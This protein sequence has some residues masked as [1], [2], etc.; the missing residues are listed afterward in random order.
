MKDYDIWIE[1]EHW[2]PGE[3]NPTNDNTDVIVT[4]SDKSRW[5]A[6]FFTYS[7][8][9]TLRQMHAASGEC[10]GG[11]YFWSS[12]MIL[13]DDTSRKSIETVIEDLIRTDDFRYV[14][15]ACGPDESEPADAPEK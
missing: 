6:S 7:N 11:K 13:I 9:E 12:D 10:L 4:F 15:D 5:V 14:F 1:A 8:V 3:W 2:V